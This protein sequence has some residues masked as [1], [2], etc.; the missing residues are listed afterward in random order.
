MRKV[1]ALITAILFIQ[2]YEIEVGKIPQNI[3]ISDKQGGKITKEPFNTSFIK[4]KVYL[5]TYTDPDFRDLNKKLFDTIKAKKYDR[6]RYNSIAIIN[7]KATWLPNFV[8]NMTLKKK[9]KKFPD[10]IFV[11]DRESVFVKKWGL[12]DNAMVVMLFNKDGKLLFIEDGQLNKKEQSK[13][14]KLIEE[15]M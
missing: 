5:V 11:E 6:S 9:Q 2:A 10:T 12:K 13:L 8:L 14:I 15:N 4:G 1:I 3:N 7:Y